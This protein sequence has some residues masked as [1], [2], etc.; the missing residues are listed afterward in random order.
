MRYAR[1]YV[2]FNELVFS[3]YEMIQEG[4]YSTS[5]KEY[6][7]DYGFKHGSYSPSKSPYA[8][9]KQTSLSVTFFLRMKKLPCDKRPFYKQFVMTQ[10]MSRG[11]L[12]AVENNTLEWAYAY[13][14]NMSELPT[15]RDDY[16]ELDVDFSLPEGVW[17]KADKQKTFLV[18]FDIC[19]FLETEVQARL[20]LRCFFLDDGLDLHLSACRSVSDDCCLCAADQIFRKRVA[21]LGK[22]QCHCDASF[23]GFDI[24]HHSQFHYILVPLCRVL[25]FL[26]PNHYVLSFHYL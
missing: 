20:L 17:H 25:H 21:V 5:M 15:K 11:K 3:E 9:A 7:Q 1:H 23:T 22:C 2:Q 10:L 12:W 8:F 13:V 26:E 19:E 4:S 24:L 18:P 14:V 16:I 6:L